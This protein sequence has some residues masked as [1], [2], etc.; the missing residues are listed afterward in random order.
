MSIL[1]NLVDEASKNMSGHNEQE[2]QT[3]KAADGNK[4]C[5]KM[6]STSAF[7]ACPE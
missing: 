7:W 2:C 4:N 6:K 5:W 1:Q 3:L